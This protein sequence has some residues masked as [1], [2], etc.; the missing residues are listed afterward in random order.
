MWEQASV[1]FMAGSQMLEDESKF[2]THFTVLLSTYKAIKDHLVSDELIPSWQT[3]RY[4]RQAYGQTQGRP[5]LGELPPSL[6]SVSEGIVTQ[7]PGLLRVSQVCYSG[8]DHVLILGI[9]CEH[10][11]SA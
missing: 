10:A 11:G 9:L 3:C 1:V 2:P 7:S 4:P 5:G 6:Q 8:L